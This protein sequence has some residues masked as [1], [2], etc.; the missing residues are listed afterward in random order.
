MPMVDTTPHGVKTL[1]PLTGCKLAGAYRAS[2]QREA[3]VGTMSRFHRTRRGDPTA[4]GEDIV[5]F[6]EPNSLDT[7]TTLTTWG[8]KLRS[9][10]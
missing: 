7:F 8:Q 1:N 5:S 3:L 6:L 9:L 2:S 4:P 10:V